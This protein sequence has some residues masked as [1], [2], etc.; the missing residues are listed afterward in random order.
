MSQVLQSALSSPWRDELFEASQIHD[1]IPNQHS[2]CGRQARHSRFIDIRSNAFRFSV[3]AGAEIGLIRLRQGYGG[4]S[5]G[6]PR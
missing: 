6:H 2:N 5:A 1:D 4:R 3:A